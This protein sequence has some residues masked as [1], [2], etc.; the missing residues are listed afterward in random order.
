LRDLLKGDK[1]LVKKSPWTYGFEAA[2]LFEARL[3]P[4]GDSYVFCKGF[5][6]HPED[7]K[8]YILAEIKRHRKDPDLEKDRMM[9]KLTKMRYKFERYKHVKIDVIYSNE[10]K[11]GI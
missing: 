3:I 7:A 2:E 10:S 6:F 9:L 5:C 4:H 11:L 8:K 1:V